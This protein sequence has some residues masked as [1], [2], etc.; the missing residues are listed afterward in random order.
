MNCRVATNLP[1]QMILGSDR[2][3]KLAEVRNL[4][5]RGALVNCGLRRERV[6][7]TVLLVLLDGGRQLNV[8]TIQAEVANAA[9]HE[10]GVRFQSMDRNDFAL[11]QNIVARHCDEPTAVRRE[12]HDGYIPHMHDWSVPDTTIAR[13]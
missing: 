12:I 8:I 5:L 2:R 10:C 6:G 4:S 7:S 3:T 13:R 1:V 11:L 9:E